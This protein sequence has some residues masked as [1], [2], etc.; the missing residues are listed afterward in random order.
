MVITNNKIAAALE[1]IQ[2]VCAR[3]KDC[4]ECELYS[5]SQGDCQLNCVP[6]ID[7]EIREPEGIGFHR[8]FD[9][10]GIMDTLYKEIEINGKE[11]IVKVEESIFSSSV[12]RPKETGFK[13]RYY[14]YFYEKKVGIF[15][16]AKIGKLL[17]ECTVETSDCP[18]F[19]E[20]VTE[21]SKY[22]Y[23][24]NIQFRNWDGKIEID[25]EEEK[26]NGQSSFKK[27]NYHRW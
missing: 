25:Q 11:Y 10:G 26:S 21:A 4:S 6:P 16:K 1:V 13:K 17:F 14:V 7:F 24:K 23:D 15:K 9:Q 8:F 2:D 3:C 27:R 20:V 12:L 22:F 18:D 5:D 19:I